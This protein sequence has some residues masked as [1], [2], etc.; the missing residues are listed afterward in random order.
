MFIIQIVDAHL[1]EVLDHHLVDN[2]VVSH[3]ALPVPGHVVALRTLV[4][5]ALLVRDAITHPVLEVS[6]AQMT[7]QQLTPLKCSLTQRT[8]L[9]DALD[10]KLLQNSDVVAVGSAHVLIEHLEDHL[11]GDAPVSDQRDLVRKVVIA[12]R[13][14]EWRGLWQL[15][16][17]PVR[18]MFVRHV[19]HQDLGVGTHGAAALDWTRDVNIIRLAVTRARPGAHVVINP[20]LVRRPELRCLAG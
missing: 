3:K 13:T 4:D 11:V 6:V 15:A 7:Q 19:S 20:G 10:L 16:G 17:E 18:K 12:Q 14:V 9:P 2:P 1:V 8:I 5:E